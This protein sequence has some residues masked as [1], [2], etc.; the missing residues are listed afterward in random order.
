[1]LLTLT[2]LVTLR[3]VWRNGPAVEEQEI[4][5]IAHLHH[6][7]RSLSD[8]RFEYVSVT[9]FSLLFAVFTP[10]LLRILLRVLAQF[11]Q[12]ECCYCALMHCPNGHMY[13]IQ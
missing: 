7:E 11:H 12:T 8:T 1:M 10:S 13:Y 3:S 6:L 9:V 4:S 5:A 2:T